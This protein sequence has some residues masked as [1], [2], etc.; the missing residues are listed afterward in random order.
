MHD[1]SLLHVGLKML[2]TRE[3]IYVYAFAG[4][5]GVAEL[6]VE[7]LLLTYACM[8]INEMTHVSY[9]SSLLSSDIESYQTQ[10]NH[11]HEYDQMGSSLCEVLHVY[12]T[13]WCK[14][15]TLCCT[16]F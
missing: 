5:D 6:F 2:S 7:F 15:F 16:I 13:S 11:N 12:C 9:L 3:C 1:N 14:V 10:S 4:D 8:R